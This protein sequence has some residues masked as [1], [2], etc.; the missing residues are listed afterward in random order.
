MDAGL[1]DAIVAEVALL[2][3]NNDLVLKM[4]LGSAGAATAGAD[5]TSFLNMP[6][7]Y[8]YV[9]CTDC[10]RETDCIAPPPLPIPGISSV[11]EGGWFLCS[12]CWLS[13]SATRPLL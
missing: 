8:M 11:S 5:L 4:T 13:H 3:F 2:L 7:D 6:V 10:M 9:S 12:L 1:P